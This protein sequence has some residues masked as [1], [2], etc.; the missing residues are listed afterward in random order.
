MPKI[1]DSVTTRVK[2]PTKIYEK[3]YLEGFGA[4]IN[5]YKK[6]ETLSTGETVTYT[7]WDEVYFRAGVKTKSGAVTWYLDENGKRRFN[8]EKFD[9]VR[10]QYDA[11]IAGRD[12][13]KEKELEQLDMTAEQEEAEK[14]FKDF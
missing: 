10:A 5:K 9:E 11:M 1:R 6:T 12:Y 7:D 2:K 3:W 8:I 14:T 13:A 4:S